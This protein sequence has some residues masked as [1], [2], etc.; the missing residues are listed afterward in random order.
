MVT[1]G[2]DAGAVR[3]VLLGAGLDARPWRFAARLGQRPV[4]LVDHPA[5]AENRA[6]RSRTLPTRPQDLRI[7]VDFARD[8]LRARLRTAG[9]TP[10]SPSVFVWEGVSM[11]LTEAAARQ[12]LA[13]IAALAGPGSLL[14]FDLWSDAGLISRLSHV[15]GGL[16]LDVLGEPLRFWCDADDVAP[17]LADAGLAL[18][19]LSNTA[20][21][22][23]GAGLGFG[24]PGMLLVRASRI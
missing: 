3:L 9:L 20:A 17:L 19:T 4:Y 7:D 13:D 10:G 21:V 1:A 14:A 22:A 11:Y 16:G 23:R 18:D 8:D 5:S 12:T 15:L 6:R 24:H 2:L